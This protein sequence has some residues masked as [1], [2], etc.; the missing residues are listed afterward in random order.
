MTRVFLISIYSLIGLAALML[1]IAEELPLPTGLTVPLAALALHLNEQKRSIR[2]TTLWANMLGLG[3]FGVAGLELM[4]AGFAGAGSAAELRVLAGAHLLTYLTWVALF[5]A[6]EGRQYWWM[7]ALSVM[8]VAVSSILTQ[9][10]AFGALLIIYVFFALW[11]LSVYSLYQARFGF[12]QAGRESLDVAIEHARTSESAVVLTS[13]IGL[14]MAHHRPDEVR[15]AIQLDPHEAWV[16]SRFVLGVLSTTLLSLLVG[17]SFFVLIPRLWV[18]GQS[19][20]GDPYDSPIRT[21]TGF[22]DEVQLGEIGQILESTE[23]VFQVRIYD[24]RTAEELSVVET[25][26]QL[27]YSEPLFRGS[28]MGQYEKGRW[29]VLDES[30]HVTP[31]LEPQSRKQHVRQ[32]YILHKAFSKTLFGMHPVNAAQSGKTF[33]AP[34][35][36]IVTSILMPAD[37]GRTVE[38]Q[39]EYVL[40]GYIPARADQRPRVTQVHN[41]RAARLREA[42]KGKL[43]Q[44]P[45]G[46]QRLRS[47]AAQVA[48]VAQGV[49]PPEDAQGRSDML[50]SIEAYLRNEDEFSYSLSAEVID[51]TIDP[52]EDFLFNR[53][54]GHCEYYASALALMLR[55]VG[56]PSR[57][58][59]G[60]KGGNHNNLSGAFVVQDR[61]AHAW[62]EAQIGGRWLTCDPTPAAARA[63]SVEEIGAGRSA[64][65]SFRDLFSG[66]W[67]QRVLRMSYEEQRRALYEPIG[68]GL[69]SIVE[70]VTSPF[71]SSGR[72]V[73]RFLSDPRRWFSLPTFVATAILCLIIVGLR[74]LWP[75]HQSLRAILWELACRLRRWLSAGSRPERIE[76]Y[77]RFATIMARNGMRRQRHQTPLEFAAACQLRLNELLT[78]NGLETFPDD[79]VRLFYRVRYGQ[80]PLSDPERTT[81]EDS[82]VRFSTTLRRVNGRSDHASRSQASG[83]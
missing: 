12:E 17:L 39:M 4:L 14:R 79:L 69:E 71:G 30:R 74:R 43:L 52:V 23:P 7:M 58:V 26:N 13:G 62:V 37:E 83:R 47:L 81:I 9:S 68:N 55:A 45:D 20:I 82:L 44:L 33:V 6:K 8:Q 60:F 67:N 1:A 66:F 16:N 42:V 53:K 70:R 35:M 22:T 49:Q 18:G 2:L 29:H 57:L 80:N 38:R 3:A 36:D 65:A 54:D 28:V 32:H 56:I 78:E 46:L 10:G 19:R 64:V 24:I 76:F 61:H 40:F 11:T 5:Q 27:G 25:S 48:G 31:L 75:E 41:G 51:P 50:R 15:G 63:A 59:S 21:V 77:E 72:E 73:A 34:A